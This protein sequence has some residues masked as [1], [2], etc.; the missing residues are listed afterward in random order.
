MNKEIV[1]SK[2]DKE[3]RL[4]SFDI[5]HKR[6]PKSESKCPSKVTA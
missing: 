1:D 5:R 3:D 6:R 2:R 4:V